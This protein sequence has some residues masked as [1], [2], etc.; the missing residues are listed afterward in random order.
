MHRDFLLEI[1]TEEIPAGVLPRALEDL[2]RLAV[3]LLAD[4]RLACGR[5]QTMGTPR[6][7]ALFIDG[8]ET[9]QGD[10][11]QE[12][13]GPP[14]SVAL[15]SDGRP[16]RAL[17]K[18][19]E[20]YASR[21]EDVT[22]VQK[23][24][25]EYAVLKRI[26]KG[27]RTEDILSERLPDLI[28]SIPFR[29]SMRWSTS[30][31][32]FVRPIQWILALYDGQPLR[33]RVG[34]I[35]SADTTMGHRVLAGQRPLPVR[36]S[37]DYRRV[38]QEHGVVL[39][40]RERESR[41]LD[42]VGRL[43]EE[44]GGVLVPDADLLETLVFL[45]EY[46]VPLRGG[47]DPGFLALP[48]EV[49]T[50]P[51]KGHQK[52]FPIYEKGGGGLLPFFIAVS[53]NRPEDPSR[54]QKGME[55][56]LKAR[57]EDA[58]FFFREDTRKPLSENLERLRGV[59]F[60]KK[61]GTSYDKVQRIGELSGFLGKEICPEMLPQLQR[62]AELCKADLV[63]QMVGEFPELQGVMGGIYAAC[64]GEDPRVAQAIREHYLP[65]A[66]EG[67][68]PESIPGAVL[69]LADKMDTVVGFFGVGNPVTGNSDPFQLRRRTIG[70]L[71]IMLHHEIE[72]PLS[73]F[74]RKSEDILGARLRKDPR[75]VLAEVADFFRQRTQSL[76]LARGFPYDTLDA[77]LAQGLER[78]PD[79][80][81]R[82]LALH[83]MRTRDADFE[84][85]L[86][87]CKRAF[88]ILQQAKREFRFCDERLPLSLSDCEEGPEKAL[89]GAILELEERVMRAME[90]KRYREVL[91]ALV[92]LKEPVDRFFDGVMVLVDDVGQRERRLRLLSRTSWLFQ[93]F[94]DFSKI[95]F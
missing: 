29:K 85:L 60:H 61:L 46:P 11:V 26:E 23:D 41:I 51:M 63:T 39:D 16:S 6:R 15:G 36:S 69:S 55:R 71:R 77:V 90:E 57:L 32:R 68:L 82:I 75:S 76:L 9:A 67:V 43:A 14:R 44:V 31:I 38:L 21:P 89:L 66:A 24:K 2:K 74:I 70:I 19:C 94:A 65:V 13:T 95:A 34:G 17:E 93:Q 45:N 84:K 42:E 79:S 73:G 48:Q 49:L 35:I 47:F 8:L 27:R 52:C 59:I 81:S 7:L 33:V 83:E 40:P 78:I 56:V 22:F 37:G 53:N 80:Y 58:R 87:G 20:R 50:A 92:G 1:G 5:V 91:Q 18:F 10:L 4:V 88:N 54:I 86:V 25:G 3:E 30:E 62:A 72:I 64:G 12:V 28:L